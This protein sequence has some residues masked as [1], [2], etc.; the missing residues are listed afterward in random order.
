[1]RLAVSG[2][3]LDSVETAIRQNTTCTIQ[4]LAEDLVSADP[5]RRRGAL[6][7]LDMEPRAT[8]L[9]PTID[10]APGD[11]MRVKLGE[12]LTAQCVREARS[13]TRG[14]LDIA[15]LMWQGDLPG[16]PGNGPLF[17]RDLGPEANAR[18][19]EAMPERTPYLYFLPTP[20]SQPTLLPYY[21]GIAVLWGNAEVA[22]P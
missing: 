22:T 2:M 14:I 15:P 10:L 3:P 12:V 4:T 5:A 21:R 16:V 1:M 17:V 8:N 13:D 11:K 7:K 9:P 18:V 19:I 20:V 6:A